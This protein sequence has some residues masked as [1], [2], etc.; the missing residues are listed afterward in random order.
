L[1][2]EHLAILSNPAQAIVPYNQDQDS[3]KNHLLAKTI[4]T[5]QHFSE[6]LEFSV[7]KEC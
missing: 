6:E 1:R 4:P 5:I 7:D 3:V 2:K